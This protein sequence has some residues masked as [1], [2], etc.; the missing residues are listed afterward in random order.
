MQAYHSG[1]SHGWNCAEAV[2]F[3][4]ADW[5]PAGRAAVDA[6]R[7]GSAKRP[8][9][10]SHDELLWRLVETAAQGEAA[11][12]K[13]RVALEPNEVLVRALFC[14]SAFL[15]IASVQ[16]AGSVRRN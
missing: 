10:F 12:P 3:A 11:P 13:Q 7:L 14:I 16:L 6:Y 15:A 1:F 2:N 8:A 9:V 4:V 5:L